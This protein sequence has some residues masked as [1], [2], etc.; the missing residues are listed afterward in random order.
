MAGY[1]ELTPAHAARRIEELTPILAS[2]RERNRSGE[3]LLHP[4]FDRVRS[5]H[6]LRG[7]HHAVGIELACYRFSRQIHAGHSSRHHRCGQ[8]RRRDHPAQL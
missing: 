5:P 4:F 7:V 2:W 8:L 1:R 6:L 3:Q